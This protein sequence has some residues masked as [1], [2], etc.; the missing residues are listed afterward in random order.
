[1]TELEEER[2]RLPLADATLLDLAEEGNL[3]A[4]K[5]VASEERLAQYLFIG[6]DNGEAWND[7]LE[8][9]R[10]IAACFDDT[11]AQ[12]HPNTVRLLL[13]RTGLE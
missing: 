1:M 9:L 7:T 5:V 12:L 13:R 4:W 10:S 6:G 11:Y 2:A 8:N 3:K